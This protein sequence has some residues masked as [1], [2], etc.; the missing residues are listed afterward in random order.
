MTTR[1]GAKHCLPPDMYASINKEP[2]NDWKVIFMQIEW[3]HSKLQMSFGHRRDIDG[4]KTQREPAQRSNRTKMQIKLEAMGNV[5]R[6][7]Y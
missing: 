5:A 2:K 1:M 6:N 7:N 4:S 3:H